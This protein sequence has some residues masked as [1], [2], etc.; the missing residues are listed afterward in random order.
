ML[1]SIIVP[2]YNVE[3]YIDRCV[4]SLINQTYKNIEILLVDDESPDNCPQI[5]DRFAQADNRIKVIHKKNGGLSD[6]RNAGIK[7]AVGDYLI[8]VDADDYIE[9]ETCELLAKYAASNCDII[10]GDAI[11]EG[12]TTD[13]SHIQFF[14]MISGYEY[15]KLA[16]K[17]D[18]APMAAWL[19][20]IRRNFLLEE[21]LLFKKGILHE[22]EEF[23]P[24]IFLKAKTVIY[25]GIVFYH[26]IIRDN[27]ITTKKNKEKNARDMYT[28]CEEL[29]LMYRGIGDKE[30]R[31]YLLDSL[32]NK[33]LSLFQAGQIYKY[34]KKYYHK[35]FMIRN[36]KSVRTKCKVLIYVFSPKIYYW[37]N[38]RIKGN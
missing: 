28:T 31:N 10:I 5:C 2:I 33:Y 7:A 15:L 25:S 32:V 24:R 37:I 36:A 17:G 35:N 23:T 4:N 12:G 21:N 38:N 6:A 30:L 19:N 26:Y 3:K 20:I 8:F 16:S 27:S 1:F 13:L 18:K 22:D 29:E 14:E 9:L 34:G 11:V